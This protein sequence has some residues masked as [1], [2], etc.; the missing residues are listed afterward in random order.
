MSI[1]V[2]FSELG[3]FLAISRILNPPLVIEQTQKFGNIFTRS[4]LK[5]KIKKVNFG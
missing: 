2:L 4:G 3:H 5:D 1:V